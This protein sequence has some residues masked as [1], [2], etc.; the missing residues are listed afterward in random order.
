MEHSSRFWLHI[1]EVSN[2]DDPEAKQNNMK[3][4]LYLNVLCSLILKGIAETTSLGDIKDKVLT[5]HRL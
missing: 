3:N 2:R 1:D 4:L 5:L